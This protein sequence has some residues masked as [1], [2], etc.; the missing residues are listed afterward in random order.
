MHDAVQ[1]ALDAVAD[2]ADPNWAALEADLSDEQTLSTLHT[3]RE[4]AAIARAHAAP[5]RPALPSLP[6]TW[7]PL[8]ARHYLARG[9]HGDVYRAWDPRLER[10]VALKLLRADEADAAETPFAITEGRLL[11][12]VQ[13]PNVVA[14]YGADRIHGQAGIW[15]ELVEGST[16][17][18]LIAQRGPLTARAALDIGIAVCSGLAAVHAAGLVHRD[19]KAQNVVRDGDGRT[20]LMDFSVGQDDSGAGEGIEGTPVYLAPELLEGSRAT[21]ASDVYAT[22][23]LLFFLVTGRY[24]LTATS[25]D[26]LRRR[27]QAGDGDRLKANRGL[28]RRFRAVVDRALSTNPSDRFSSA[29]EMRAALTSALSGRGRVFASAIAAATAAIVAGVGA[30]ALLLSGGGDLPSPAAGG[31]VDVSTQQAT[32]RRIRLPHYAMGGP[33]ADGTEFPYTDETGHLYI[34]EVAT[35]RSRLIAEASPAA[36]SGHATSMSSDGDAV[37]YGWRLPDGAYELRVMSSSGMT[38]RTLIPRQTA[39]EPVPVEWS[40]DGRSLL[41]WLRQRNGTSDLVLLP[42]DGGASHLLQTLPSR[43]LEHASLSPD[44]RWVLLS[45]GFSAESSHGLRIIETTGASEAR[46]LMVTAANERLARWTPDGTHLLFLRD[47][48]SIRPSRDAWTVTIREGELQGEPVLATPNLGAVTS[49]ALTQGGAMH[50]ILSTTSADVYTASVDLSGA[51]APGP[52]TRIAPS[53][54]GNHVAPSWSPDGRFLAFFTTSSTTP[55]ATPK[56]TLTIKDTV[57]GALRPVPVPL[58]FVAGYTPRWAPDGRHVIILGRNENREE[59]FGYFQVEVDTGDMTPVATVG[60]NA[61]AFSQYSRD[62]RHFFYVHPPRGLVARNLSTGEEQV[63]IARGQHS[64]LGPF[65]IAPDGETI[66]LVG[67]T[68]TNGR[69]VTTLQVQRLPGRP[70]E[71]ARAVAPAWVSLHAWTPDGQGLLFTRGSGTNPYKLWRISAQGSDLTDMHFSITPSPNPISLSPD[72]QQ[73]AYTERVMQHELW[74]T[75][76]PVMA[77]R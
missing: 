58:L 37:A 41:C 2:S 40:R 13:H 73:I 44:A 20:I 65:V 10:E 66:A 29:D 22:G 11:A 1:Q 56:R 32:P 74:I 49:I 75:P 24:P 34:W 26:E 60:M 7:G 5:T 70:R 57:S 62:G 14:V 31:A 71:L 51:T 17:R 42:T 36:G 8:E 69:Q 76:A 16:V 18:D 15:M 50:R 35:G 23:V 53:A 9:A 12:R 55:G 43:E 33:S 59:A 38:P 30:G 46:V 39:Y 28:P 21:V 48:P 4:I 67:T 68:Q 25:L 6:F 63:A 52:P 54:I 3:L 64:A 77:G 72:G 61:P 27:H 47:S 45:A 19:V